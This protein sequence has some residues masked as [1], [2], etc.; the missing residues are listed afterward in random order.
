ML[1]VR[2]PIAAA[3][4]AGDTTV[5][6]AAPVA[7][8]V[9]DAPVILIELVVDKHRAQSAKSARSIAITILRA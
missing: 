7:V 6:D 5:D 2:L 3:A 1:S 4:A 8:I 9:D